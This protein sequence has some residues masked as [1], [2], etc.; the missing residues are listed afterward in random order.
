MRRTSA[1][2]FVLAALLVLSACSPPGPV[3]NQASAPSSTPPNRYGAPEVRAPRDVRPSAANPCGLLTAAQLRELG[4][5]PTGQQR[6]DIVGDPECSW[7]SGSVNQRASLVLSPTTD[8]LAAAYR[9]RVQPIFEPTEIGGLPAVE[10]RSG[11]LDSDCRI[12]VG[13]NEGQGL[14]LNFYVFDPPPGDDPNNPCGRGQRV[15]EGIVGNLPPLTK[16]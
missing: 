5:S 8:I 11:T 10:E 13:T 15:A 12:I 1:L 2:L 16:N 3:L 6:T 9:A 4:L 14:I 7:G